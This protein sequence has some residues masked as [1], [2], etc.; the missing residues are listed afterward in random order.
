MRITKLHIDGFGKFHDYTLSF[1]DGINII[2][3]PNEAGKSTLHL[4]IRSMLYGADKKR[5]G[6]MKPI[7]ERM[8]PWGTPEVYGGSLEISLCGRQYRIERNFAAAAD[9]IRV[10]DTENGSYIADTADFMKKLLNEL[11]ETAY[12][13]TVS[14]GQLQAATG[15]DMAAEIRRYA[16][17]ITETAN[18]GLSA[19]KALSFLKDQKKKTEEKIDLGAQTEYNR[20]LVRIKRAEEALRDP[21][22][23]NRIPEISRANEALSKSADETAVSLG[24]NE[25]KIKEYAGKLSEKGIDG[26]KDAE[27]LKGRAEAL[28]SEYTDVKRAFPLYIVSVLICLAAAAAG[29]LLCLKNI[30]GIADSLDDYAVIFI[31][32]PAA[33][34][35]CALL[36]LIKA[37]QLK[38]VQSADADEL[39]EILKKHLGGERTVCVS[40]M[41]ELNT[42]IDKYFAEARILKEAEE[43]RDGLVS[44]L[45]GYNTE[46]REQLSELEE[47]KRIRD[48][49]NEELIKLNELRS[50]AAVLK[51]KTEENQRLRDEI[52]SIELAS[53]TLIRLSEGIRDAA[54]TYINKEASDMI[55]GFTGGRYN[56]INVGAG[57]DAELNCADG[58]ISVSDVSQGTADQIYMAVRLAAIRFIAGDDDPI[59]LILDD[60]FALYDDDRLK[61]SMS[62]LADSFKGQILIFTCQKREDEILSAAGIEHTALSIGA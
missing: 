19:D 26:E 18:P 22:K 37:V 31:I 24:H 44:R 62:F 61:G 13:N 5:H 16:A 59:P 56:S 7:F 28:Y 17:N 27:E 41:E 40:A 54:G 4:F 30:G 53:D 8:R 29:I 2:T 23:N 55:S 60:S 33:L 52:E 48:A 6:A 43:Y 14:S 25:L 35:L 50:E 3:G 51:R 15:R 58:M 36:M 11:S 39:S 1:G 34:I 21:K 49:V 10:F 57:M 32:I 9:D 45:Q 47:Q 42:Q 20:V 12:I 46:Q 38:R